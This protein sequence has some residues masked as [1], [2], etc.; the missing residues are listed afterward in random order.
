[1][2][3]LRLSFRKQGDKEFY[4]RLKLVLSQKAWQK[5][6]RH[7][8][9]VDNGAGTGGRGGAGIDGI[10]QNMGL[11]SRKAESNVQEAFQDMEALMLRAGEMVR[12]VLRNV[13]WFILTTICIQVN[14]V[15]QLNSKLS[16]HGDA[17]VGEEDQTFVRSALVQMGL[18]APAITKDQMDDEQEYL[19]GLAEELGMLLTGSKGR[20][21]LMVGGDGRGLV[22]S[23]EVWG[24][25]NRA[26]GICESASPF[27]LASI[28][29]NARTL[30]LVSPKVMKDVLRY[31]PE[32][33]RPPVRSLRLPSGSVLHT[34]IYA[35]PALAHRLRAQLTP[36][37]QADGEPSLTTLDIAMQEGLTVS[38]CKE[39]LDVIALQVGTLVIDEQG[40]QGG[41]DR[42]FR[43]IILDQPLAVWSST[44]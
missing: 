13:F 33:T 34:P 31:L 11:E 21:G 1:M 35:P 12:R 24:L 7:G 6:H 32:Y 25:W 37:E 10:M 19:R 15:K 2:E 41:G 4:R 9:K 43:N 26:R 23:D 28:R 27:R 18:P 17:G 42:W 8:A 20:P 39:I 14:L 36:A 40:N 22:G 30:A 38:V 5:G 16:A 29:S 3:I 44:S